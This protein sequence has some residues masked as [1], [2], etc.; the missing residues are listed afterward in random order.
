MRPAVG[1][2][3]AWL[4]ASLE[5]R[6]GSSRSEGNLPAE[7]QGIDRG[8]KAPGLL[9][10]HV[11]ESSLHLRHPH[12]SPRFHQPFHLRVVLV[13]GCS[14]GQQVVGVFYVDQ[15]ANRQE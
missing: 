14:E 12:R 6:A 11:T 1:R 3:S 7:S 2:V 13:G 9:V 15:L 10:G 4:T 5:S 8:G